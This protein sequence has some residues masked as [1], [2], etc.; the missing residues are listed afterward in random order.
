MENHILILIHVTDRMKNVPDMQSIFSEFGCFIKTR[1]GLHE[2]SKEFCSPAGI[3][4]LEMLDDD[5]KIAEME[6]KLAKIEGIDFEKVVF[7]H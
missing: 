7:E 6:A 4:M 3:V 2:A 1:L 5:E